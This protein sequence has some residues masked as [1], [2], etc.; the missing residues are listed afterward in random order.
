MRHRAIQEG[1][2]RILYVTDAGQSSHFDQVFQVGRRAGFHLKNLPTMV[3]E[4]VS[5]PTQIQ[6]EHVPFGLV[7][8]EDGKK[9]QTRSGDTVKLKDLLDEAVRIAKKDLLERTQENGFRWHS[10]EADSDQIDYEHVAEVIGIGAV[11]YADLAMNRE[12]N[13]R[14]SYSKMLALNGNTA[15]YMLYSYA[16]IQGILRNTKR[17]P[18]SND[19]GY[20]SVVL[21]HP[22]EIALAT[23]LVRL[24]DVLVRLENELCPNLLCDYLFETSQK[25][26]KV[27]KKLFFA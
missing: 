9:F 4:E 21:E 23:Q 18:S 13:Y 26:N 10:N 12:S 27:K 3:N 25:F 17:E 16:R 11:K 6:L 5:M 24:P 1:A 15:P 8:G 14:F 20:F 19:L 7:Q 22:A 2:D